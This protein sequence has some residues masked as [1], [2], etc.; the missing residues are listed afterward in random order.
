MCLVHELE[1]TCFWQ[2]NELI[3]SCSRSFHGLVMATLSPWPNGLEKKGKTIG[4]RFPTLC[5]VIP[6][7]CHM[8][9]D[10]NELSKEGFN[11]LLDMCHFLIWLVKLELMVT[12]SSCQ[13]V[14][15]LDWIAHVSFSCWDFHVSWAGSTGPCSW[16]SLG[17]S[18][19]TRWIVL[20]WVMY[21]GFC[22]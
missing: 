3:S 4:W 17:L 13:V 11:P 18:I 22:S 16:A 10:E 6:V 15:K 8:R 1:S 9:N 5:Y 20:P 12:S 21:M 7:L 14:L 2:D 19:P